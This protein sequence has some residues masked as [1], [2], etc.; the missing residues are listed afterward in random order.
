[1][2]DLT[3]DRGDSGRR[4]DLV[5]VRRLVDL[6]GIT[7]TRVQAWIENGHVCVNGRTI[8]RPAA[9]TALGDRIVVSAIHAVRRVPMAAENIALDVLYED[10]D[11]LAINK[12]AGLVVH[13]TFRH[14]GGTIMNALLW[15]AA[16]WPAPQRPSLVGRLDKLT[17]GI[18]LAAKTPAAHA[19]MQRVLMHA[20]AAKDYLALVYGRVTVPSGRIALGLARDA[21]D[22]RRVVAAE[23]RGVASVTLFERLARVRAP[24]AGLSLLRCRLVT[25]RTHQIR[26]HL[27]E[28]GFPILADP[29]YGRPARDPRLLEAAA[30]VGH[31]ALHARLLG[32]Q[33][34]VSGEDVR[35]SADPPPEFQRALELLRS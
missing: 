6:P 17:T 22:R 13:P 3:A 5:L 34:P 8:R 16:A 31:Q 24:R 2:R 1:M 19:A 26:V 11:L 28:H 23:D 21:G 20:S 29:V 15:R 7:R 32:F 27:A 33:H 9:R 14:A 18:L 4:L 12:P 25:G 30:C 10:D 35:Y